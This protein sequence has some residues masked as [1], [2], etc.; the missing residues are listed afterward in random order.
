M[1]ILDD[2]LVAWLDAHAEALD[3]D[4]SGT[5]DGR[6]LA[7]QQARMLAQRM[8][9]VDLAGTAV[10]LELQALGGR[11]FLRTDRSGFMRRWREAAFLPLLTPTLVQLKTQVI[12]SLKPH[13]GV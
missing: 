1:T 10:R 7:A 6:T 4:L 9:M 11:A 8:R 12:A 13:P 2:A 5:I 3:G